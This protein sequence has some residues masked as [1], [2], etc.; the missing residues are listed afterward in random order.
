MTWPVAR[1]PDR[2][3]AKKVNVLGVVCDS[4]LEGDRWLQLSLMARAGEIRNLKTE[5]V[6]LEAE[7]RAIEGR[8]LD[9]FS[10]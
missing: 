8:V 1:N 7:L 5:V 4:K 2:N 3:S 10:G 6:Q 9:A